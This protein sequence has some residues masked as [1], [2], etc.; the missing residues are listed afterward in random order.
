[1]I[2][3]P[4]QEQSS[5]LESVVLALSAVRAVH[6]A[7][8]IQVIGAL[9]FVWMMGRVPE[10]RADARRRTLVHAGMF[11]AVV[12][13]P[14]GLG[15]LLMQ[16]ADMTGH[17]IAESWKDGAVGLLLFK[18]HAGVVWW[19]RFGI[20]TALL[21]DL[22]V[23]AYRHVVP[24]EAALALAL[25]LSIANF[26]SCAWLS[27]AASDASRYASLHLG[28]HALHM[29][30]VSLWLGGFVPM[31]ILVSR[32]V[33][34]GNRDGAAIAAHAVSSW[35][36]NI[37][38][39]A[40]GIIVVSGIATTALV[41][42]DATDLTTGNYA[43]LLAIKLVLFGLMLVLAGVNRLRLVPRLTNSDPGPAATLL[44]WS[45][46]AELVLGLVILAVAG[47]L[48]VTSPGV[49]E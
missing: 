4:A 40:V 23:L 33:R 38:L 22:C 1:L 32:A 39:L 26:I 11:L 14:S 7:V 31:G 42:R 3:D 24:S 49:D 45:V 30:G 18:T 13:F 29:L 8:A 28:A 15:W 35:F 27:H 44:C 6:F 5:W 10:L 43:G 2:H 37:A 46:L 19:V 17:T 34:S 47:A 20:A 36:G 16:A 12:V 21:I 48:G 25:V 41:V 9:L